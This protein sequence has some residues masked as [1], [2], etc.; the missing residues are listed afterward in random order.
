MYRLEQQP[1][2]F[3]LGGINV[4]EIEKFL[5]LAQAKP[6]LLAA[7][8]QDHARS[9]ALR[10]HAIVPGAPGRDEALVLIEP[11]GACGHAQVEGQLGHRIELSRRLSVSFRQ[12]AGT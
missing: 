5:D 11:D 3:R 2:L 9:I 7:Q 8:D 6:E 10:V 4:V 12:R 1:K